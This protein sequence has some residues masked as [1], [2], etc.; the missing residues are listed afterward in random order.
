MQIKS[1]RFVISNTD[2]KKCPA[3]SLPE[4]AFIGRSN[5]GKS[6]IINL[7]SN[8]SNLAKISSSPGKTQLINHF[9]INE[10]WYLV[11]LP[12]YGFAKTSKSLRETWAG[13]MKD[14]LIHRQNLICIFVLIDI[15]LKPQ[16][17]DLEFMEKLALAQLPFCMVFTKADKLSKN[18]VKINLDIYTKSMKQKWEYL[19]S[20]IVTS[21]RTGMGREELLNYIETL[22]YSDFAK[23]IKSGQFVNK[24]Q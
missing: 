8:N 24:N 12:G 10:E 11:D 14:Y 22:N 16:T 9:I 20:Y 5:V 17:K 4:Y 2:F 21:S 23:E 18:Q 3:P 1:A 13:F 19:P 15:R 7:I 6:S